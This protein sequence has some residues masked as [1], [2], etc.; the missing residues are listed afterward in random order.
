MVNRDRGTTQVRIR[1]I[2]ASGRQ[3]E[4]VVRLHDYPDWTVVAPPDSGPI[5][6]IEIEFDRFRRTG[7]GA[8]RCQGLQ[9][10]VVSGGVYRLSALMIAR[11]PGGLSGVSTFCSP[12]AILA[13]NSCQFMSVSGGRIKYAGLTIRNN[14]MNA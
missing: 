13:A 10:E 14:S 5:A 8:G 6:R 3:T 4:T 12:A 7:P 2:S 11:H 9:H 1:F